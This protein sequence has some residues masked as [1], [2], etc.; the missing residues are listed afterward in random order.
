MSSLHDFHC[1]FVF[2]FVARTCNYFIRPPIGGRVCVTLRTIGSR[3]CFAFK[4]GAARN[5]IVLQPTKTAMI[6]CD[7]AGDVQ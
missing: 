7:L 1:V 6:F 4:A 2:Y 3:F 5:V